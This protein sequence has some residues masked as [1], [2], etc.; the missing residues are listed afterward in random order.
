MFKAKTALFLIAALASAGAWA[1]QANTTA[2]NKGTDQPRGVVTGGDAQTGI[3]LQSDSARTNANLPAVSGGV[4]L[5]ARDNMRTQERDAN[6]KLVFALNT[7]NY[8]SDVQVKV[9]DSKGR[10]VINDVS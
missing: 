8:V 9:T 10:V 1:Q 6:V 7:G 4:S 5:N 3:S 2:A